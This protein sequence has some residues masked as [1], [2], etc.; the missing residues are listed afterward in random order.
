M[1][2]FFLPVNLFSEFTSVSTRRGEIT[3]GNEKS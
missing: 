3:G 2:D 1:A